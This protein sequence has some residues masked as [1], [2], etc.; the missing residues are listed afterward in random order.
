MK[1][2]HGFLE[3]SIKYISMILL[4]L[5]TV[6]TLLFQNSISF[7]IFEIS[8]INSNGIKFIIVSLISVILLYFV[9]LLLRKIPEQV[10]FVL[11]SVIYITFGVYLITN[12]HWNLRDDSAICFWSAL[13]FFEGNFKALHPGE[14]FYMNPHQLGLVSYNALLLWLNENQ[15][16][17]FCVNLFW[18]WLTN[19]CL[20]RTMA[21]LCEKNSLLRKL[22]I[23]FSF[24]FLPQFFY[25][26]FVYGQVPGLGCLAVAVY[27]AVRTIKK[28]SKW[29]A[30]L[31]CLFIA[32]ACVIRKN[33][34]IG[35]IALLIVFLLK[36]LKDK[37]IFYVVV[38]LGIICAMIFPNRCVRAYYENIADTDLSQGIPSVL[39]VAMGLQECTEGWRAAGWFNGFNHDTYRATNYDVELSAQIAMEAID[40]RIQTFAKD[41]G[42][43][44]EFFGEKIISTW[45][46]PTFQS[47]WSGPLMSIRNNETE[48]GFI[49]DIYSGGMSYLV[50]SSS[51]NILN[52]LIFGFALFYV[53]WK[54]VLRKEGLHTVELFG[55]L[56]LT[57]G[58]LFHLFWETSSKYVYPYVVMIIPVA[59]CGMNIAFELIE[60]K[61]KKR[62]KTGE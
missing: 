21:L 62:L 55:I 51:M 36:A 43:A 32:G 25:L 3:G 61:V 19:L 31:S 48:E 57:G 42:Y 54:T 8:T 11:F 50:L 56:F 14:Y 35:G 38:S 5:L 41:P 12:V 34:L 30:L 39:Y 9:C 59:V 45:C 18:I 40:E 4:L 23:V 52:V 58:F 47:V 2:L 28:D 26:F 60:G 49:R 33:Y 16:F 20:W 46:E 10:L 22:I 7:D 44:L 6:L 17:A 37:R 13:N 15:E 53:F 27:F 24:L 1:K 29:S